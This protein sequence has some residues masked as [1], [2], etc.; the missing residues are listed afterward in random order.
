MR[1]LILE[2]SL[3]LAGALSDYLELRGCAV[4][5]AFHGQAFLDLAKG[6]RFDVYVLDVAV[7]G[8]DGLEVCERLRSEMRDETPV[9]F[10]T[11]RD[12]LQD[13]KVG[14]ARGADDYLVKPFEMEELLLRLQALTARGRR[15]EV[16]TQVLGEVMLDHGAGLVVRNGRRIR[17]HELQWRVLKILAARSPLTVERAVLERELWGDDVPDSDALRTHIYRLRNALTITGERELIETV[18]G[19]GWRLVR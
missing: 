3:A 8:I 12:T 15:P 19:K 11:A 14:F 13:K 2:D 4:D 9:I 1:V 17:L 18:H 10:L 5:L 16:S 6:A 7:P